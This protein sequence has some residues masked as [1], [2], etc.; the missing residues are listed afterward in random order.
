MA[1]NSYHDNMSA[2]APSFWTMNFRYVH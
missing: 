2:F 1:S